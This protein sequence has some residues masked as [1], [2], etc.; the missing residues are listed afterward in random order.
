MSSVLT[1]VRLAWL[2]RAATLAAAAWLAFAIASLLHVEHAFWAAM[3]TWV[4]AQSSRG[5][6]IERALFRLLGTLIGAGVGLVILSL[7]LP[8]DAKCVLLALWIGAQAGLTHL[9]RGA[10]SY[11]ALMAGITAGVVL[12]PALVSGVDSTEIALAR[13]ECTVIGV[14]VAS[15]VLAALT[16]ASPISE[17]YAQIDQLAQRTQQLA[18]AFFASV[19]PKDQMLRQLLAD[20][21]ALDAR[22]RL[23]VAGSLG[24]YQRMPEVDHLLVSCLDLLAAAQALRQAGL[25]PPTGILP[26]IAQATLLLAP[27]SHPALQ[28]L[29]EAKQ[30]LTAHPGKPQKYAGTNPL[31]ALAPHREWAQALRQALFAAGVAFAALA[32]A[33]ITHRPELELLALGMCTFVLVLGSVPDPRALAPKLAIGVSCGALLGMI[34]RLGLQPLVH[35]PLTLVLSVVPFV[36]IGSLLRTHPRTAIPAVDINMCF[37]LGSQAGQ[38]AQPDAMRIIFESGALAVAAALIAGLFLVWPTYRQRLSREAL[39]TLRRDLLRILDIPAAQAKTRWNTNQ[40]SQILRLALHLARSPALG[41]HWPVALLECL[42]LAHGLIT[43]KPEDAAA[44]ARISAYLAGDMPF[45]TL[46]QECDREANPDLARAIQGAAPLLE[47]AV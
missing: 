15:I 7:P 16:P 26:Q 17:L 34:Y 35:D 44:R 4:L 14:I 13:V 10:S 28:R 27:A 45:S 40:R 30:S 43:M 5:Q 20:L 23:A 22:T 47:K 24:G 8:A 2:K 6:V 9:M 41:K 32:I 3:P 38:S 46:T 21:G 39:G 1:P 19:P 36:I 29:R 25:Q 33:R 18:T 12:I 42:N 11:L 31:L 37:W